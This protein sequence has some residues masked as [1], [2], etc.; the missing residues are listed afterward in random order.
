MNLTINL[1]Q[2]IAP[3]EVVNHKFVKPVVIKSR[4]LS[5]FSGHDRF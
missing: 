5:E 4:L 1:D 3:T 2:L